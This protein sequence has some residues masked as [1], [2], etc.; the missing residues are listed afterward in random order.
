LAVLDLGV[1]I[2]PGEACVPGTFGKVA[3]SEAFL[4]SCMYSE[5]FPAILTPGG[6][7]MP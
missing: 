1:D 4:T 3:L 2:Y 5:A 6:K 7:L